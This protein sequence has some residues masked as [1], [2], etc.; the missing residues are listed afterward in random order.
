MLPCGDQ[1]FGNVWKSLP[2]FSLLMLDLKAFSPV[3]LPIDDF[4]SQIANN[5]A[6]SAFK[7]PQREKTQREKL[8]E[9]VFY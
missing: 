4:H 2:V 5:D 3:R 8:K 6:S 1:E 7:D 9:T